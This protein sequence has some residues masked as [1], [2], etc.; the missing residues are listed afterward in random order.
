MVTNK[1]IGRKI[2]SLRIEKKLSQ[3]ELAYGI[4]AQSQLSKMEHGERDIPIDALSKISQR[5]NMPLVDFL[6][7][8]IDA[9]T[10]GGIN[11]VFPYVFAEDDTL[12][13]A[14]HVTILE[15]ELQRTFKPGRTP[16]GSE[17]KLMAMIGACYFELEEYEKASYYFNDCCTLLVNEPKIFQYVEVAQFFVYSAKTERKLGHYLEALDTLKE[18]INLSVAGDKLADIEEL[19]FEKSQNEYRIGNVAQ[20]DHDLLQAFYFGNMKKKW[21][22]S[23][24]VRKVALDLNLPICKAAM[25]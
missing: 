9:M 23:S 10:D 6:T 25:Q 11:T 17:L 13:L 18:G 8:E 1:E 5:L 12:N 15:E 2:K 7:L 21:A 20:A 14:E 22:F 24:E 4:C 3:E 16:M 19:F